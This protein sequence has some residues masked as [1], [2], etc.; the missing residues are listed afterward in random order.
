MMSALLHR[1]GRP[2]EAALALSLAEANDV[3]LRQ[4]GAAPL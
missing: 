3:H 2:N 4:R 1:I